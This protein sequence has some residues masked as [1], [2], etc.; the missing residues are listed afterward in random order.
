MI[1]EFQYFRVVTGHISPELVWDRLR[2]CP[3]RV[4]F[5]PHHYILS[6][7]VLTVSLMYEPAL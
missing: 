5:T 4:A 7:H 6:H 2:A 1:T 3:M